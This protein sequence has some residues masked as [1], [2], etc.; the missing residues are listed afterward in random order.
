MDQACTRVARL[1]SEARTDELVAEIGRYL[2][3]VDVF[4]ELGHEPYWRPEGPSALATRITAWLDT[5]E[6]QMS[7][8]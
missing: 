5:R 1:A 3:A 4:R 6:S 7:G 8:V 2:D